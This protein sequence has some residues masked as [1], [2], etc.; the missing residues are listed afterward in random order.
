MVWPGPPRTTS[1][2]WISTPT[3]A[4]MR[5]PP[6]RRIGFARC[7]QSCEE[8]DLHLGIHTLSAVNVAEFSPY[9]SEAVDAYIRANVDL[10]KQLSVDHVITHAGLHQSSEL[11]L[12]YPASVEHLLARGGLRRCGGRDFA[13]GEFELRAAGGRGPLHG[14]FHRGAVR[15]LGEDSRRRPQVGHVGES[16]PP[17][18][19]RFRLVPGRVRGEPHR[20]GAGRRQSRQVRGA[21]AA[22]AGHHG[23][24][25]LF[26]RLEGGGY[27][28]PVHADIRQP[29]AKNR[30]PRVSVGQERVG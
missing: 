3:T 15:V 7:A 12:R 13:A 26:K 18:A 29:R 22:R 16:H 24:L 2:F 9:M 28:G 27:R 30:G 4:R 14:A 20:A 1:T 19:G 11:D 17:A 10:G 21:P 25:R 23:F 8:H 6:G 5:W